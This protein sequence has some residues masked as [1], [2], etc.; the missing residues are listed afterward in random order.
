[1]SP[2]AVND[3]ST[4]FPGRAIV[5]N[6]YGCSGTMISRGTMITAAHCVYDTYDNHYI[7]TEFWP[8]EN[9]DHSVAQKPYGSVAFG[10]YDCATAVVPQPYKDLPD[11]S[12]D[13]QWDFAV[14]D[15]NSLYYVGGQWVSC[16]K[17]KGD[18]TGWLGW[19]IIQPSELAQFAT[20]LKGYPSCLN[21]YNCEHGY[22]EYE[23]DMAPMFGQ[24]TAPGGSYISSPAYV[25]RSNLLTY[26]GSSGSGL[27]VLE[28]DYPYLVGTLSESDSRFRRFDAT[29]RDFV[30]TNSDYI[31]TTDYWGPTSNQVY[32]CDSREPE[33]STFCSVECPCVYAEGDCD[34]PVPQQ[35]VPGLVCATD[36]GPGYGMG[37][38]YDVCLPATCA[39]RTL[40]TA[41][42]CSSG[43]KCGHGGG[44]CNYDSHCLP[45]LHCGNNN[46]AAY[47]YAATVD[48]CV[49]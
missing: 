15:F 32:D 38:T 39:A 47:G 20:H 6:E 40:G 13:S 28:F 16:E 43:C 9:L 3:G 14:V 23:G 35:C 2:I 25:I 19:W 7:D 26:P 21:Q 10:L 30:S 11:E 41:G 8:G 42:Y 18:Q 17:A 48:V 31:E 36:K 4:D 34:E 12:G 46:G 29:V 33:T 45:G 44:D 1:L 49:P 37:P 5:W 22:L 27:H 24:S